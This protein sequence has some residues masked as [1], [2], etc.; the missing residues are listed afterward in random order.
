MIRLPRHPDGPAIVGYARTGHRMPLPSQQRALEEAGVTLVLAEAP[1][2]TAPG[3]AWQQATG[4][5]RAGDTLLVVTLSRIAGGAVGCAA[6]IRRLDRRGITVEA[7]RGPQGRPWSTARPEGRAYLDALA[8][9]DAVA[10]AVA[11]E[12]HTDRHPP[13]Y[14]PKPKMGRPPALTRAQKQLV[15]E[16][17]A[18][19]HPEDGRPLWTTQAIAGYLEVGTAT[20]ARVLREARDAQAALDAARDRA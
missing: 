13:S 1:A 10:D 15:L 4:W 19:V 7:L 6:T 18:E 3:T 17:F 8:V 2:A 12:L 9:T 20:I 16:L 14:A 5:M 11:A